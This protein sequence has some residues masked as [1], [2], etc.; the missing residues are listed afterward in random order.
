M[1]TDLKKVFFRL[2]SPYE[3]GKGMSSELFEIFNKEALDIIKKI[4]FNIANDG[5]SSFSC[6][7][8][9]KG[10]ENLYMHPMDFSGILSNES[11]L[12][13]KEIIECAEKESSIFSVRSIDIF[14]LEEHHQKY[15]ES[16]LEKQKKLDNQ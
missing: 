8:G 1:K 2:N 7:E 13:A 12:K 16:N 14:D 11:F 5:S 3:W 4:G 15:I 10:E 6:P 9:V